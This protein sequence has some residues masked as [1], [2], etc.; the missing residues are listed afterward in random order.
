MS[1]EHNHPPRCCCAFSNQP[2]PDDTCPACPEHGE[3]APGVECPQCHQ[4]AG[5]PHTDYCTLAPGAVWDGVLPC[6]TCSGPSR[7]TVGMVCQTCGTDYGRPNLAAVPEHN[8]SNPGDRVVAGGPRY[9]P[10]TGED[11][12]IHA[13]CG[14]PEGHHSTTGDCPCRCCGQLPF[15]V[16]RK[17]CPATARQ[18]CTC[19][20]QQIQTTGHACQ[21]P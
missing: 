3:L 14:W 16:E 4:P 6:P 15:R 8:P 17:S 13:A 19:S 9:D 1:A 12:P 10:P 2:G 7:E 5:R 20:W 18:P 11:G 21:L